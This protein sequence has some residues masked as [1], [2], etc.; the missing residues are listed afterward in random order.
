MIRIN[1]LPHRQMRR[2]K[3]QREF[4][5]MLATAGI[6]GLTILILGQTYLSNAV[7]EQ[8]SRNA[9]LTT[10]ITN[11]DKDLVEIKAL[12]SKINDVIE[13][14]KIVENL[15]ENRSQAVI[16]LDEITRKLP[17]GVILKSIKQQGNDINIVGVADTNARV[18]TL[19]R[20]LNSSEYLE[21]PN[22]VEIKSESLNNARQNIFTL[23]LVQKQREIKDEPKSGTNQAKKLIG[24]AP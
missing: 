7:S 18:A 8:E 19:V 12:K 14:K 4:N 17:E 10:A 23:T 20:N 3:R 24:H 9:R 11:Y 13:R 21:A 22:L 16:L 5:F 1:L 15:Q 6:A 2:A